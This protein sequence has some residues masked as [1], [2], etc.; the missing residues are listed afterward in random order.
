MA[1]DA[2]A[3]PAANDKRERSRR[4]T[5]RQLLFALGAGAGLSAA[6]GWYAIAYEPRH[7]AVEHVDLALPDFPAP[8]T[9][10]QISDLHMRHPNAYW[11]RVRREVNAIDADFL[12]V[13]GDLVEDYALLEPCLDWLAGLRCQNP[14]YFVAGNWEHLSGTLKRG[15]DY[16]LTE[17]GFRVLDNTGAA[18]PWRGGAFYMAGVNDWRSGAAHFDLALRDQPPGMCTILLT[19]EPIVADALT[20]SK[21]RADLVLAGHTHGGQ[22]RLPLLGALAT[23]NGS[24]RYEQ[25]L[26]RFARTVMYVNRGLGVASIHARF[27]CPPEITR[28]TLHGA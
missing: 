2:S 19:H 14:P 24:G 9:V 7:Y 16:R 15:L 17:I 26:Y 4:L 10:V 11:D 3:V 20:V 23:P 1:K 5:R 12:V 25:G 13:T 21:Y 27:L 8:A 18:V 28:F 6:G 22:I